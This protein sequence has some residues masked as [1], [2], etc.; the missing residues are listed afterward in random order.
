MA[1]LIRSRS[2]RRPLLATGGALGALLV[3]LASAATSG[4][5][6]GACGLPSTTPV[7]IDYGEGTVKPD[8]REV[9]ARPGVVVASS[10][11]AIPKYFRDHGAGTTYFVLHLPALVGEPSDPADPASIGNASD[12][13][14]AR[15]VDS[16]DCPTPWIALNELFGTGLATPWSR[17]NTQY[18]ANV[19]ALVQRLRARGAHP[20][21]LLQGNPNTAGDAAD[22]W[23][24]VAQAGDIVYE[25]Y[26][27]ATRI[28][29][30]G[31]VVGTRRMRLGERSVIYQFERLGITP[32]RL[33]IVLG[34]HSARTAG[35]GGRQG[36]EPTEAWLRIVKWEA[37]EALQVAQD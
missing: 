37:V 20:A 28:S 13:L 3:A 31:A 6:A 25:S 29:A 1:Q 16:T 5:A 15:A 36:L 11:T 14:Y 19:L 22:W 2:L 21:L 35:I 33:G 34:F 32:D 23:R 30:L 7:W 17:T 9:L 24:Q 26:Y 10:G 4:Q 12:K 8:V 18:R 27:D